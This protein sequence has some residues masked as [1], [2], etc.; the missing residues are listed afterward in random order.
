MLHP[1][2]LKRP[3]LG[4]G[5]RR[6]SR[7]SVVDG[8]AQHVASI[9]LPLHT[10]AVCSG[11]KVVRPALSTA[12]RGLKPTLQRKQ[13]SVVNAAGNGTWPS[14]LQQAKIKVRDA[15]LCVASLHKD[16]H[17]RSSTNAISGK[18]PVVFL[19][20]NTVIN[21]QVIG[22]GGGGSNAVNR[23][24]EGDLQGVELWVV[25]TDAQVSL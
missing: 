21:C 10:N 25:N 2:G 24:K 11:D 14:G 5:Q 23:M 13:V 19:Q 9:R 12:R 18:L 3:L 15:A 17:I 4:L 8:A 22:V 1:A 16:R 6:T 20:A 7:T